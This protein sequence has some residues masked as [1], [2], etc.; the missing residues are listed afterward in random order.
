MRTPIA[1]AFMLLSGAGFAPAAFS[2]QSALAKVQACAAVA[3]D[4]ARLACYDAAVSAL[5]SAEPAA[6]SAVA[7][8]PAATVSIAPRPST[9]V[10]PKKPDTP[11]SMTL[12]V[13]AIST[14]ADGKLRFTLSNGEVWRQTDTIKLKNLGKGPWTA[15]VRKAALGSYMLK[16]DDKPPVRALRIE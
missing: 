9:I 14:G 10:P 11:D 3:G 5:K 1:L 7:A 6:P 12:G 16:V 13:T 4:T 8:A 15:E 2:Q